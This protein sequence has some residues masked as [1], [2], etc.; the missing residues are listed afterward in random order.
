MVAASL[1]ANQKMAM[2]AGEQYLHPE[3]LAEAL[4]DIP[5][6]AKQ[7]MV[8]AI[9]KRAGVPLSVGAARQF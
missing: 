5:P 7:Q 2:K 9:M 3:Q 4:Q 6:S 1:R 8:E